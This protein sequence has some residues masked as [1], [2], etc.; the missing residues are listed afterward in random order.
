MTK[1][2]WPQAFGQIGPLVGNFMS[3]R[4]LEQTLAVVFVM[5][6]LIL[7]IEVIH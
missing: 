2:D 7:I 1:P 6:A 4:T 5:V 3:Q